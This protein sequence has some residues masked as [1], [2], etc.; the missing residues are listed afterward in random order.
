MNFHS[1]NGRRDGVGSI[2]Q[3][4]QIGVGKNLTENFETLFPSSHVGE[5]I[6]NERNL[7]GTA[8]GVLKPAVRFQGFGGVTSLSEFDGRLR[9]IRLRVPKTVNPF[10]YLQSPADSIFPGKL[11]DPVKAFLL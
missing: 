5:P 8:I 7:H 1:S 9:S 3:G 10:V 2:N 6:V 4:V 11:H